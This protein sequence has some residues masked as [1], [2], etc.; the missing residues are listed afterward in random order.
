MPLPD[1]LEDG[2]AEDGPTGLNSSSLAPRSC[3]VLPPPG[4]V[5]WFGSVATGVVVSARWRF[6]A[7]VVRTISE[8]KVPV[9]TAMME[10]VGGTVFAVSMPVS[11]LLPRP[12]LSVGDGIFA[13]ALMTV[14]AVVVI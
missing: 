8:L 2:E 5:A 11:S 1:V 12:I 9:L 6:T 14:K 13:K 7:M 4:Y 3:A 10:T